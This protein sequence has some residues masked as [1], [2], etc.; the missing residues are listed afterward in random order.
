MAV[1]AGNMSFS[2]NTKR[3]RIR[4]FTEEDIEDFISFMTDPDSTKFLAFA[5]EQKNREGAEKLLRLT[6]E[7]YGSETPL[8]AFAVDCHSTGSF[9][10][11]CGLTPRE[12]RDVEIMYAVMSGDRGKGYAA[13]IVASLA[14]YAVSQLGFQRVTAPISPK[15]QASKAVAE[16]A[17]FV[18][19]GIVQSSEFTEKV[20]LFVF[21]QSSN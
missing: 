7:S 1:S 17:G 12:G 19:R 5:E 18:D 8:M 2:I 15:H 20:H 16:K 21:E 6:I 9:V 11:F 3:L 14:Q 10:G 13:E 4:Q